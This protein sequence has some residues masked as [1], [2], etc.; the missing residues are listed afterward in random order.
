MIEKY[1]PS[2][3]EATKTTPD[4]WEVIKLAKKTGEKKI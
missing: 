1:C 3:F 2:Y 4:S